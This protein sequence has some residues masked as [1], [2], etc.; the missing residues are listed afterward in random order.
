MKTIHLCLLV[1]ISLLS[2]CSGSSN[3]KEKIETGYDL[4]VQFNPP[5]Y[6]CYKA[7]ADIRID[8]VLSA[9]EWGAVPRISDFV[10]IAG[11]NQARPFLETSVKMAYTDQG[12]YLAVLME[13]PHVWADM[14]EHDSPLFLNNNFEFFFNPAN[15]T[16]N[17]VEYEINAL[18]TEWDLFLTKPYRDGGLS[19]SNW[20]FMGM[21][22]ALH[23]DGTLND[24]RDTDT[25]WSV[26]I[27]LPWR[28]VYQLT[29]GKNKPEVGDQIRAN[30]SRARW[31]AE[32][33]DGKYVKIPYA[34]DDKVRSRFWAWAPSNA[35]NVHMPEFWG[36]VQ[37][38]GL[39][40]GAGED[41]FVKHADEETKWILRNLYYRQ[42]QYYKAWGEYAASLTDLKAD[43]ACPEEWLARLTLHRTARM[44]EITL[45]SPDGNV[46][47][48]R[49]DGLVWSD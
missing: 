30:F 12:L 39:Q 18:G 45:P 48:I 2:S 15:D 5:V 22:S 21:E 13:E 11:D 38:S 25:S 3:P 10:D 24:P 1:S 42:N 9:E 32:I 43:E 20:E 14:T 28:S 26:E 49:Q 33:Q 35:N 16:H 7:P 17:Y 47:S 40:A 6:V 37:L 8:G 31:N 23:I 46:W 27:F 34:G 41:T 44:Y 19:F 29:P 36:F 4:P